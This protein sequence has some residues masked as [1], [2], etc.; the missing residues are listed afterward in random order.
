MNATREMTTKSRRPARNG[1]ANRQ[2]RI[3]DNGSEETKADRAVAG[4]IRSRE[5]LEL[6]AFIPVEP[7]PMAKR[8]IN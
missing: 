1:K 4:K 7:F 3:K 8:L 6:M 5:I 2:N